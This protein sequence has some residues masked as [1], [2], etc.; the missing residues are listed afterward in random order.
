M[1]FAS[2]L[3]DMGVSFIN[4][5]MTLIAFL[6][7]LVTLSNM[8]RTC[9]SS[10]IPYGLV[11]A[12]IV[13]SLMGTGLLAGGGSNCRA[14]SLKT[15]AW[16]AYRKELVYGEDDAT[17]ATPPTVR[18]LFA[19]C[20]AKLFP[21]LFSTICISTSPAFSICRW[22]TFSALSCCFRRLLPVRLPSA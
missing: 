12:A 5:V 6:P 2:T 14:W 22:I 15:S 13:W 16:R 3:E 4:A 1:R 21:S 18:E 9:L 20:V 19:P 11:I 10:A 7:V 8:F 17:R